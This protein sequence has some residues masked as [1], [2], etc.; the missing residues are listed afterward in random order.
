MDTG[1]SADIL[2]LPA[3]LQMG[4]DVAL[5]HKIHTPLV[6]FTGNTLHPLGIVR[7][8]VEFGTPPRT[9]AMMVD[10]LVVD[11]PSA[12]NAILGRGT[13][14]AIGA[15]ISPAHLKLKF[16]TDQGVGEER[17]H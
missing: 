10:F 16:L 4:Y 9:I 8:R 17:G 6:G 12:Y 3:F 15:V 1:S 5:L 13:L 11:A 7:I 2:Y 14:N